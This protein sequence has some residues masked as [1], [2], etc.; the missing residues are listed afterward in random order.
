MLEL[1]P[2]LPQ[3]IVDP[4]QI[5]QA[6]AEVV[7]HPTHLV[8]P[9]HSPLLSGVLAGPG[10]RIGARHGRDGGRHYLAENPNRIRSILPVG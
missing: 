2:S 6:T 5:R 1:G 3:H 7:T 9:G 8:S 10:K 4:P